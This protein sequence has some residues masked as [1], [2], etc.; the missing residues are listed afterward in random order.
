MNQ[1]TEITRIVLESCGLPNDEA[2]VKKTIPTWWVNTRNKPTGGLR[3]T[4]QGFDALKKAD[5][6]CYELKFDEPIQYTNELAIWIDQN[7]DCPF[8][9]TN[10][11]IWVFGEKMAVKLVLFSG[12]IAKFHRA[13]K[14]F[15][16][17]Q[18]NS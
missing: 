18:K 15:A 8:Y 6:K 1:K 16:E 12:N 7:I 13:Q 14:R 9:L 17:K 10:K 3:L 4:E 11:K 2:R 5:I